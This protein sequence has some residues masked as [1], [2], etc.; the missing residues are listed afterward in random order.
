MSLINCIRVN[1]RHVAIITLFMT[2]ITAATVYSTAMSEKVD[3]YCDGEVITVNR[4][5]KSVYQVLTE[6]GITL[7]TYDDVIPGMDVRVQNVDNIFVKR[8]VKVT[9]K[10]KGVKTEYM[11]STDTVEEFLKA[12][13]LTASKGDLVVP[14]LTEKITEGM[15]ISVT[16][17]EC[18]ITN[19][20]EEIPYETEKQ[21]NDTLPKNL[22]SITRYGVK[23]TRTKTIETIYREGV[24]ISQEVVADVVTKEPVT[25][26]LDVGT[27]E[28]VVMAPDGSVY[29][30][31]KMI[32]CTATAYDASYE[33]NGKWGPIT[34]TGKALDSGMVAVD[35]RVI[36]LG[37]KLYIEA[38][39]GSWVYGYSVA[40][41]TGGAIKGN[42]V[43]LFF[44][45]PTKVRQFGRRTANVYVLN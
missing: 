25:E 27:R 8:A 23:G 19:V 7:G 42:K 34:A 18:V 37:T 17:G 38:P 6:N 5:S 40:E 45:S 4:T 24:Q 13:G 32:T 12:K 3:I 35:P 21:L 11:T 33:S 26:I 29:S 20:T 39:D 30:Y 22:V 31:S 43:D 10:E 16:R 15:E 44:H 36:P 2:L 1:L 9:V 28:N 14:A 41:D